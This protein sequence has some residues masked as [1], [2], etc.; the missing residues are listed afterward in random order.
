MNEMQRVQ[1][2]CLLLFVT[3]KLQ[4]LRTQLSH[5]T[6]QL[7]NIHHINECVHPNANNQQQQNKKSI[8]LMHILLLLYRPNVNQKRK[9]IV[10]VA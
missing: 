3:N 8:Q 9:N 2:V 6:I 10:R 4:G 1:L 5:T 7:L